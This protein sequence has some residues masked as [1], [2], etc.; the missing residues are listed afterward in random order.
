MPAPRAQPAPAAPRPDW[1]DVV[2]R[3]LDAGDGALLP[4]SGATERP[5]AA[6]RASA[7][8]LLFGPYPMGGD[9]V[10]LTERSSS[11]RSHAGQVSFPGGAIDASDAGPTAAALREAREEVGVD[12]AG[13]EVVA[14][15]TTLFLPPSGFLVTPVLAWWASPAPLTVV[16]PREVAAVVRVPLAELIDPANRFVVT[17]PSG[18]TGPGFD[19]AGLFVWGFTAG[20]LSGVLDLAGL[21]RAWDTGRRRPLPDRFQPRS[22]VP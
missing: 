19:V 20:V 21:S 10:V 15:L 5:T 4:P 18:Y 7:V 13:V 1:L 8:L 14:E 16:E 9:D 11:M 22:A 6:V 3:R 12:P 17:H 2:V